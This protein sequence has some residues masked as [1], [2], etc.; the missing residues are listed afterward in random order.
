[1]AQHSGFAGAGLASRI[2]CAVLGLAIALLASCATTVIEPPV[3]MSKRIQTTEFRMVS[4]ASSWIYVPDGLLT[5]ERNLGPSSE[6]RIV[7]PNNTVVPGDNYILLR[8]R[9][10]AGLRAG[11]FNLET[12]LG[13]TVGV[14]SP[15][16]SLSN[17]DMQTATDAL[18]TYFWASR[19]MGPGVTCMVAIRSLDR[20]SR[21]L[22][23]NA[24]A[25]DIL[26][27]N[28]TDQGQAAA[29]EPVLAPRLT[30]DQAVAPTHE[31]TAF[32][33]VSPF[34]APIMDGRR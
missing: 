25:V 28:C 13:Q 23:A 7:L 3:Q 22:P 19:V 15:F 2:R 33:N 8:S 21:L 5:L 26:M 6:Q 29:L 14:P 18:G 24:D 11:R 9:R 17:R 31:R 16:R 10:S 12:F 4:A 32:R 34:A 30:R 1:M 27:R 20:D